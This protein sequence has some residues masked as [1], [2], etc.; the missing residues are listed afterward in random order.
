[1]KRILSEQ[2]KIEELITP[3]ADRHGHDQRYA[4]DP[5][6]AN[7]KLNWNSTT[8]FEDGIKLTIDWYKENQW[9]FA[10]CNKTYQE[11]L[12]KNNTDRK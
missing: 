7:A 2:G 4:F 6:K 11:W 3:V 12:N 1:V 10:E 8:T 5:A 9:W